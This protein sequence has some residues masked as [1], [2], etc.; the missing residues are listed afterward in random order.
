ME[1]T[2]NAKK[3]EIRKLRIPGILYFLLGKE[4]D[5]GDDWDLGIVSVLSLI[6]I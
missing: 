2:V 3:N 6:H 4:E 5:E 1:S